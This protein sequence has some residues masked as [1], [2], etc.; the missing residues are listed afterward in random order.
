MATLVSSVARFKARVREYQKHGAM[1]AVM[2]YNRAWYAV[3]QEKEWLFGPS[4]FVGYDDLSA[5]DYLATNDSLDGRVTEGVL[6]KWA[7]PV[8]DGHPLYE[9]LHAALDEFCARFG[10]KPNSLA[11]IS[12]VKAK[13]EASASEPMFADE[14]VSLMAAVYRKLSPAQKSAF[15]KQVA[16]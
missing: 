1:A 15:K 5:N 4:K 12:I 13:G 7:E 10:K 3:R 8:E 9:E 2:P 11:R 6:Q 14:L 16:A